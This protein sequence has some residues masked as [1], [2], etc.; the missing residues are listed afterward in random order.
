MRSAISVLLLVVACGPAGAPQVT[1]TRTLAPGL[2]A[3]LASEFF[4]VS[5]APQERAEVTSPVTIVFSRPL[6]SLELAEN[7]P[8]PAIT[9]EPAPTGTWQWDGTNAVT[10]TSASFLFNAATRYR[11][12]VPKGL[13]AADGTSLKEPFVFEFETPRPVLKALVPSGRPDMLAPD[14]W[15]EVEYD[16]PIDPKA[17]QAAMT[18]SVG[19][20][21]SARTI[22]VDVQPNPDVSYGFEVRP[23]ERL[24]LNAEIE[25]SIAADLVGLSG[26][27]PVGRAERYEFRTYGPLAVVTDCELP[28][29][30][31][32]PPILRFSTPVK[33][34][35]LRR[36]L[37]V[38][39]PD[40]LLWHK[41]ETELTSLPLRSPLREKVTYTIS[42]GAELKDVFGQPLGKRFETKFRMAPAPPELAVGAEDGFLEPAQGTSLSLASSKLPAIELTTVALSPRD[43]ASFFAPE[44]Q[45][46]S[47]AQIAFLRA[48]PQAKKQLLPVPA[49]LEAFKAQNF[50]LTRALEGQRWGSVALI[51]EG[52]GIEQPELHL[53]HPTDL[54][55]TSKLSRRGGLVWV[56][57]LSDG[58]PVPGALV[59]LSGLGTDRELVAD[60]QGVARLSAED[61]AGLKAAD[62][63]ALLVARSGADWAYQRVDAARDTPPYDYGSDPDYEPRALSRMFVDRGIYRPGEPV[64]VKGWVRRETERGTAPLTGLSL[65]LSLRYRGQPLAEK[66]VKSNEFGGYSVKY[67]LPRHAS[68]GDYSV[69]VESEQLRSEASFSVGE[70]RSAEFAAEL[71]AEQRSVVRGEKASFNLSGQ[72]LFG[73]K[74]AGATAE[75]KTVFERTSFQPLGSEGFATDAWQQLA[76]KPLLGSEEMRAASLDA[77]G[78]Y[79]GQA[80]SNYGGAG[81]VKLDL[82]AAVSDV[83]LQQTGAADSVLVHPGRFYLGVKRPAQIPLARQAFLPEVIAVEPDGKRRP[84]VA[85]TLE[86]YQR[87][88][89]ETPRTRDKSAPISSCKLTTTVTSASCALTAPDA[90]Q[91]Y[92]LA[93]SKD[94]HDNPLYAADWLWVSRDETQVVRRRLPQADES[95]SEPE[96]RLDKEKYRPG[97]TARAMVRVPW[98]NAEVLLTLE[99]AGVYWSE[100]RR[101]ADGSG[102]FSIPVGE[103]VATNATLALHV[104]R[105]RTKPVSR[106]M[107][108]EDHGKPALL[109]TS[110]ELVIDEELKRLRVEVQ[111]ALSEA[112]PG[113]RVKVRL[114]VRDAEGHGRRAELAVYAVDEGVLMLTGY[115]TPDVLLDFTPQRPNM[116]GF[117]DT[118]WSLGRLYDPSTGYGVGHGRLGGSHAAGEIKL[119]QGGGSAARRNFATTPY[120]AP[121][122]LTDDRGEAEVTIPLA[123]SLTRYRVMAVATTID[124]R[125][126]SGEAGIATSLKLMARPA[127]PRFARVGDRFQA[128]VALTS[129]GFE[130]GAVRVKITTQG[131]TLLGPSEKIVKLGR[132]A[133][134]DVAFAVSAQSAGKA[135]VRFDIQAGDRHDSVEHELPVTLP[136]V[137]QAVA[138]YGKVERVAG[139]RLGDLRAMRRDYGGLEVSVSST[140]LVGLDHGFDQ[141]IEYPYGCTEQLSSRLMPLLP[142]RDLA[143]D[144]GIALPAKLDDEVEA[145]IGKIVERQQ[146][147]G[148]FGLWPGSRS[149]PWLTAYVFRTLDEAK[150]RGAAVPDPVLAQASAYLDRFLKAGE[151][152]NVTRA[153]V[154]Y[155]LAENGRTD[156]GL[157]RTLYANERDLPLFAR[158]FLLHAF[159]LAR[160]GDAAFQEKRKEA[161][162]KLSKLLASSVHVDGNRAL[163]NTESKGYDSLFDSA[164]RSTA[165]VLRALLAANP[166]HPLAERLARGLLSQRREGSWRS[167]QE[168]SFALLALDAYRRAQEVE[169]P[170]FEAIVWLGQR[171]LGQSA[172]RGRSLT[173]QNLNVGVASLDPSQNVLAIK[174]VG[175]GELFYEALLRYAPKELPK[176]ELDRGF[177]VQHALYRLPRRLANDN[178]F[179]AGE[180]VI[181]EVTL[182][183]PSP[184]SFVVIDVPLPAG[185]EAV[186]HE[187]RTTSAVVGAP[188]QS[189]PWSHRELRDD[190]VLYFA[191][192][193]RPGMVRFQ[194]LMRATTRGSFV[195]PPV[196]AMEMY[197]PE[198]FGRSAAR[199]VEI[200]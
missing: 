88:G 73:A 68:L 138:A 38:A 147:D 175:S 150:K 95:E 6:R 54:A 200:R 25:L 89:S 117:A 99:G 79:R 112:E 31:N 124:D 22:G 122:V 66:V 101:L 4:V 85:V 187:L 171:K 75:L 44:T 77:Q 96:L 195:V 86:L 35:A 116:L 169:A 53:L 193:L 159:A 158:A 61:L 105:R 87:Q 182:L 132:D 130:P 115:Q 36:A 123:E 143:K 58:R 84:G 64:Y 106:K 149:A 146:S 98:Q 40:G 111:P 91:Y 148:G 128:A 81:P 11:V 23:L 9:V 32:S 1:A 129:K 166:K 42:V 178:Q 15:F 33:V 144:F 162:D 186:D 181:G 135:R 29:D 63:R 13:R 199:K 190:R 39:P 83:T 7:T 43:L 24:P 3:Q 180:A 198:V 172:H 90:D 52:A 71:V 72:Y 16:R 174:K 37:A 12:T 192:A 50:S 21:Q 173:V 151:K 110:T 184:R 107:L 56:T 118:R 127:L 103:R 177:T 49:P 10:L 57:R 188:D 133:S 108:G 17:L 137:P 62:H 97:D 47:E 2:E 92:V 139:E 93:T 183:T 26:P 191:D 156:H 5:A 8:V 60:A 109:T 141:L 100:Q 27:L 125:F 34:G 69:V 20:Q 194:Y 76:N 164:G 153:Y 74:M 18:L 104:T 155:V 165:L 179:A 168:T 142:L 196:R 51:A 28:Q 59:E 136:I 120:F 126:G 14:A 45:D 134:V 102:E 55:L 160:G 154:A 131:L 170:N 185:L 176:T 140:A 41:D 113:E 48:L 80:S 189:G 70:Y 157:L 197:A 94:E 19:S 152:D 121:S 167:T 161:I 78:R 145:T 65:R 30:C 114:R 119:R 163:V 46:S 82:Y 67:S